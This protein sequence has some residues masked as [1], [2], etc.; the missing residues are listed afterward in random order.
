MSAFKTPILFLVFN[1]PE[2]TNQVFKKIREAKP[3]RLYVA[4][5]GARDTISNE[6]DKIQKVREIATKV[7]WPCK[8]HTLFRDRNLGCKKAV[9]EA[10]TW[11]FE[12]EKQGIIL[13]DDCLPHL[14][15]FNFCDDLLNRYADDER[16]SVITGNNFQ[17]G[18]IRGDASYYFSK[19]NH[20]W[21]WAS[22]RR[23]WQY[24]EGE[25]NFWKEWSKSET[26]RKHTPNK[27]ERNYWNNVFNLVHAK[28][29]DSWAYPW[30]ASV[31]HING[32]T[33]TP[34]VNLVS[35]IGFGNDGTHTKSEQSKFSKIS[36]KSLGTLRHPSFIKRDFDADTYA[37]DNHFQGKNLRFPYKWIIFPKRLISY[38][39]QN[40][41]NIFKK[42]LR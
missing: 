26:W 2:S 38:I 8:L 41:K 29:V 7:D 34:N 11:F 16:V 15:F 36:V 23:A 4:G 13:E 5:D 42:I 18:N 10:I 30:T 28:K 21:G 6:Q 22:W 33:V 12:N 27:I 25:L 40:I 31:W 3:S 14:D 9:S 17:T 32:L 39:F 19:Y 20:C 24:Y 1:R 35:N 37:F